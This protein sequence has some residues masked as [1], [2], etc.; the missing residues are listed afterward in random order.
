LVLTVEADE[1]AFSALDPAEKRR[2]AEML[3]R[4]LEAEQAKVIDA[5][6]ENGAC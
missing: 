6:P 5:K 2:L 3:Y 4:Q 1:S